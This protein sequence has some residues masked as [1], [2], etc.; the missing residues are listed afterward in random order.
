VVS[1][2]LGRSKKV[3]Y[4][5]LKCAPR[6]RSTKLS[7]SERPHRFRLKIFPLGKTYYR[8][9]NLARTPP[10]HRIFRPFCRHSFEESLDGAVPHV[11]N[12]TTAG[13][14]P[15]G[16][17]GFPLASDGLI[18]VGGV[19]LL[20]NVCDP[21]WTPRLS[22]QTLQFNRSVVELPNHDSIGLHWPRL[23]WQPEQFNHVL[24]G[25]ATVVLGFLA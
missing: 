25:V 20:R 7:G 14:V 13:F 9:L 10:R 4:E 8:N 18:D 22:M 1:E 16:L 17:G 21:C 5:P 3:V 24:F 19:K 2:P 12:V 11:N 6:S 15:K 23:T